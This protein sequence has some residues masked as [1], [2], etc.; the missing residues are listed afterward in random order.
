[1]NKIDEFTELTPHKSILFVNED[2]VLNRF[3]DKFFANQPYKFTF[4]TS[5]ETLA[6]L[7]E[8]QIPDLV[9]IDA[10]LSGRDGLYWIRWLQ[11]YYA[12]LPVIMVSAVT[13]KLYRLQSLKA[14]AKD[15]LIKP[16]HEEE[17]LI[18][19]NYILEKLS[20]P[21]IELNFQIGDASIDISNCRLIKADDEIPLTQLEI[22][23]LQ[24][25]RLNAGTPVSREDIITQVRG[26]KYNP[27]DRSI[28]V[29]INKLRKKLEDNPAQPRYIR[30]VRGKGYCLHTN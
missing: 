18:R 21:K 1:M 30:T 20:A 28:D 23:L 9:V 25:L 13:D 7:L 8:R 19:I 11:Q 27:M 5:G 12:Y 14:G 2:E 10:V 6:L 4:V 17:L 26:T 22:K 24:L 15:Y 29:H 16:F 3:L